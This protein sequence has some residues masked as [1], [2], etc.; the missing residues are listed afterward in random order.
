MMILPSKIRLLHVRR[1]QKQF[2]FHDP[3]IIVMGETPVWNDMVSNTTVEETG[4]KEVP[5]KSTGQDKVRVSVFLAGEVDGTRLK[6]F[7]V[8]KRTNQESKAHHNEFNRQCSAASSANGWM[9]E[10]L[11]LRWCN[12]ILGQFSFC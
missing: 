6:P 8:F 3:N 4:S 1:I 2:N 10:E 9:N 11:T 12:K 5:M 7:I